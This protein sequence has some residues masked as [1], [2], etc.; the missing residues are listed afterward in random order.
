[1]TF[2]ALYCGFVLFS[3]VFEVFQPYMEIFYLYNS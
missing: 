3:H 2:N 1:M